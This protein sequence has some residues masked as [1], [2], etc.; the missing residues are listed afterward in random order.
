MR[1]HDDEHRAAS[2]PAADLDRSIAGIAANLGPRAR[3]GNASSAIV[4]EERNARRCLTMTLGRPGSPD[5]A[6]RRLAMGRDRG[7]EYTLSKPLIR[8]RPVRGTAI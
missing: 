7:P 6:R 1:R 3:R 8:C 4:P 5:P 2:D